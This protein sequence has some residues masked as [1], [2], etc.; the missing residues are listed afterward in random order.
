MPKRLQI[1]D[2]D[3]TRA[4]EE[5]DGIRSRAA[6]SLG[7]SPRTLARRLASNPA[8]ALSREDLEARELFEVIKATYDAAV[9]RNV[10]AIIR[11]LKWLG[12]DR[13]V[14]TPQP[15]VESVFAV[16]FVAAPVDSGVT[17]ETS[18]AETGEPVDELGQT[19]KSDS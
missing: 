1:T 5:A 13:T 14:R 3:I 19:R 11:F 8:L 15:A 6:H 7:I 10:Y 17:A 16:R 9:G 4:L 2:S 18:P 12:W